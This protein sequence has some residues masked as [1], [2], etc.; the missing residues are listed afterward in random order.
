MGRI[1][2]GYTSQRG[3]GPTYTYEATWHEAGDGIIWSATLRLRGE[4]V[5][6]PSGQIRN[7]GGLKVADDVRRSVELA[8]EKHAS[9][10]RP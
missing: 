1:A 5:G 2:G 8:I 3:D 6:A 10:R 9:G 7:T 4:V